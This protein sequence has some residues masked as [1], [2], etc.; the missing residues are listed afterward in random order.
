MAK[1]LPGVTR[2]TVIDNPSLERDLKSNAVINRNTSAYMARTS[3]KN[4]HRVQ[5]DEVSALREEI[6]QLKTLVDSLIRAK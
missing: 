4:A 1:K 5:K 2:A 3:H 6:K